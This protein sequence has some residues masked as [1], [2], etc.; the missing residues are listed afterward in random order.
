VSVADTFTYSTSRTDL[1]PHT[2]LMRIRF[3]L[4]EPL[5]ETISMT[6]S[7]ATSTWQTVATCDDLREEKELD[8]G[9]YGAFVVKP[10]E[11]DPHWGTH[12]DVR[13]R[14]LNV[15]PRMLAVDDAGKQHE[16]KLINNDNVGPDE[17]QTSFVF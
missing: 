1:D 12:V 11:H 7:L 5:P 15:I 3:G 4:N 10:P 17:A 2:R 6:I 16:H 13:H 14:Q 9:E 8:G